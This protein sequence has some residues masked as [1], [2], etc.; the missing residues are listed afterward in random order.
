MVTKRDENFMIDKQA[1]ALPHPLLQT[2]TP[3]PLRAPGITILPQPSF[4]LHVRAFFSASLSGC[5]TLP[6]GEIPKFRRNC[7]RRTKLW[8][9]LRPWLR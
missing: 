2:S 7:E 4:C 9:W 6:L 1:N 5:L 8:N 3:F